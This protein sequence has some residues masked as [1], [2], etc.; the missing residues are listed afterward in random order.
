MLSLVRKH[1][2]WLPRTILSHAYK[3]FHVVCLSCQTRSAQESL[4]ART[5][6]TS[7]ALLHG[8]GRRCVGRWCSTCSRNHDRS[9]T[10]HGE[11][12]G[13]SSTR[14]PQLWTGSAEADSPGFHG[15]PLR[16][17]DLDA[18]GLE[19]RRQVKPLCLACDWGLWVQES[20]FRF[21]SLAGWWGTH[22]QACFRFGWSPLTIPWALVVGWRHKYHLCR[23]CPQRTETFLPS[24]EVQAAR[25]A[26]VLLKSE[27]R[28]C[29][30]PGGAYAGRSSPGIGRSCIVSWWS[31]PGAFDFAGL[32]CLPVDGRDYQ[33][34]SF[35]NSCRPRFGARRLGSARHQNLQTK[36]WKCG[37]VGS[38]F[39]PFCTSSAWFNHCWLRRRSHPQPVPCQITASAGLPTI[40]R[41]GIHWYSL[42]RGG[43]S[44]AFATGTHFDALLLL[45]RWQSVKTAR[46][47]LVSGRAALVQL[48]LS[49]TSIQLV[50]KFRDKM[51][52]FSEQ[53]RQRRTSQR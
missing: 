52:L 47:Y 5:I 7:G 21:L 42:R 53:L 31:P 49:P 28:A 39:S 25:V 3:W 20:P 6:F 18:V 4:A 24:T 32:Y 26:A 37:N 14:F 1:S 48:R 17:S 27:E 10:C 22:S 50:Q 46:Q 19:L 45:G 15:G 40:G 43:A 38:Q 33:L 11:R 36:A 34:K 51:P 9:S 30:S 12:L 8:F 35:T 13:C 41:P 16:L 29:S 2:N 44:H 23:A